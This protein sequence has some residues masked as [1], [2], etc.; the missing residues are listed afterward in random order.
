[1]ATSR[2]IS[3]SPTF[4]TSLTRSTRSPAALTT[5]TTATT[6]STSSLSTSPSVLYRYRS[7]LTKRA[8]LS[9]ATSS[10][11][12]IA[13]RSRPSPSLRN[14]RHRRRRAPKNWSN[15][16]IVSHAGQASSRSTQAAP[17][18]SS[19]DTFR[20]VGEHTFYITLTDAIPR[21]QDRPYLYE[22]CFFPYSTEP[23]LPLV[24]RRLYPLPQSHH[25]IESQARCL[26]YSRASCRRVLRQ[27]RGHR[28]GGRRLPALRSCSSS[29]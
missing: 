21:T 20:T 22:L 28:P 5:P 29:P 27:S 3:T 25:P 26:P 6:C 19:T 13:A 7:V 14:D 24:R 1:M 9:S 2:P 8:H 12:Y 15:T 23:P 17:P 16:N 18:T 11:P 10:T 4:A